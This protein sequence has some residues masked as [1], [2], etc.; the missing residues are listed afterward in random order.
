VPTERVSELC[1]FD[2]DHTLVRSPL[3]LRAMRAE[4]RALARE[5]GLTLPETA[6]GWTV[7]QTI[8]AIGGMAAGVEAE[9]WTIVLDHET[10]ALEHV[11]AEPG[12]RETLEALAA[13]GFPLGVWT[14]NARPAAEVALARAG[15]AAFFG[16]VVT[17]DEAAL[18][19]DPDGLR[20]LRAAYPERPVWVIGDSWIDGAAARAGGAGF[21]AY[22]ADAAELARR[23]V[24]ADAVLHDL[25]QL[26]AWLLAARGGAGSAGAPGTPE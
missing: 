15:L 18:K 25:R 10:R 20:V 17:R 12:A 5:R 9:A 19:P 8:A 7:A 1:V 21:V 24:A 23:A 16:V 3:D 4:V 26:P 2:L 13:A 22:G 14:N 11:E 6:A